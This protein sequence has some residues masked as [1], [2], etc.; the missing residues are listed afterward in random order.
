MDFTLW[1]LSDHF[2]CRS[3]LSNL[4]NLAGESSALTLMVYFA[5]RGGLISGNAGAKDLSPYGLGAL[6]GLAGMFSKQARDK[7]QG[8]LR[9]SVQDNQSANSS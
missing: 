8:G 1:R 2:E 9:E 6:A 4:Q 3:D 5:A 7:F